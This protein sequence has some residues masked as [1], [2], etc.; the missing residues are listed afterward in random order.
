MLAYLGLG[1]LGSLMPDLDADNSAPVRAAFTLAS[2]GLAFAVMF[3]LAD[4]FPSVAELTALWLSVYLVFR[5]LVFALFTRL[6]THRGTFHSL[7]AAA[8]FGMLAAI[9]AERLLEQPALRA[10]LAGS[11]LSFGYLVHL[12]LDEIYSVNL[13]G[14]RSK[15]SLGSA[16]KLW[17][18]DNFVASAF[19]YCACALAYLFAPDPAGF[20]HM[21]A[22]PHTYTQIRTHLT[23]ES[24]WFLP[25]LPAPAGSDGVASRPAP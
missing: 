23:P 13:F 6:T 11:F 5:W 20:F 10:W 24:G 7:P 3:L 1:T 12:A 18:P 2:I 9:A 15:R 8:L 21:T 19:A 17:S 22:S 14:V 4:V 25:L 16:L